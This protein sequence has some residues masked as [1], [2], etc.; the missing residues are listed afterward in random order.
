MHLDQQE[1]KT[2][3]LLIDNNALL[4]DSLIQ[5]FQEN[6]DLCFHSAC[7]PCPSTLTAGSIECRRIDV[8]ILDPS[9]SQVGPI[10]TLEILRSWIGN[11]EAVAYLPE[12]KPVLAHD[13]M[14][15]GFS[16][17]LSRSATRDE[18]ADAIWAA[19]TGGS[20]FD[21]RFG[22]LMGL[23]NRVRHGTE[24]LSNRE[25]EVLKSVATGK[26]CREIGK[27]LS[28]SGKTVET[29]KYRGM[30]KLG[31]TSVAGLVDHA[32]ANGWDGTSPHAR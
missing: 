17:V 6:D 10:A 7:S 19:S 24:G 18:L 16:V 11:A 8:V 1:I 31:L 20:L 5:G 25:S 27:A 26:V 13:C 30:A 2:Q 23:E 15:A 14:K 9:Q 28:I 22:S 12:N 29:H 32:R 21:C 4:L 3:V